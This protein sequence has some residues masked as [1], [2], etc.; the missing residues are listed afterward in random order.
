[1]MHRPAPPEHLA[2]RRSGTIQFGSLGATTR[3]LALSV[4]NAGGGAWPL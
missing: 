1:M 2:W 3:V 4:V